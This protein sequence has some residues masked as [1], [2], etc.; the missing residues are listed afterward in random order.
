MVADGSSIPCP[1]YDFNC[2]YF[3]ASA[4]DI[5]GDS[6]ILKRSCSPFVFGTA[7]INED[8]LTA[9]FFTNGAAANAPRNASSARRNVL[10]AL[11]TKTGR[12]PVI[13]P[14]CKALLLTADQNLLVRCAATCRWM[15]LTASKDKS[16]IFLFILLVLK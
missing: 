10:Y 1:V 13:L 5:T 3:A 9:I 2:G 14:C 11:G 6:T 8:L 12:L 7:M 4:A 15:Q 16:S